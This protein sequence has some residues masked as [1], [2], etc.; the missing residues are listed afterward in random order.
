MKKVADK[1][2]SKL[3]EAGLETS[4]SK[5]EEYQKK[6]GSAVYQP[7]LPRTDLPEGY[8]EYKLKIPQYLL[9]SPSL[10]P[11]DPEKLDKLA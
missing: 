8:K 4:P 2:N 1:A 5:L 7:S 11:D 10:L 6:A 3:A 9:T